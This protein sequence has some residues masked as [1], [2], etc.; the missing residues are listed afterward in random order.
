METTG[1]IQHDEKGGRFVTAAGNEEARL[2]YRRS[3]SVMDIYYTY[4]PESMRGQRIAERLSD[5]AFAYAK[6]EGLKII[7]SCPYVGVTYLKRHPEHQELI[8]TD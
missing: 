3:G 5:A 1:P 7:P 4:V 8:Q 2:Q 6:T